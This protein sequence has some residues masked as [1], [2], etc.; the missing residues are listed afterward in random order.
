MFFFNHMAI[1]R[2]FL[3]SNPHYF[4]FVWWRSNGIICIGVV[5]C[6]YRNGLCL[7]SFSYTLLLLIDIRMDGDYYYVRMDKYLLSSATDFFFFL[8]SKTH[9]LCVLITTKTIEYQKR[10]MFDEREKERKSL[11]NKHMLMTFN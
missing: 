8:F 3:L 10:K 9:S 6:I 7:L 2:N 5:M 1:K 11:S 4:F